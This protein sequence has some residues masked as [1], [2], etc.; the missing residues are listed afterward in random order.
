MDNKKFIFGVIALL[1]LMIGGTYAYYKW[2]STENINVNVKIEGGSVTFN[3]GSNI[4]GVLIP[5]AT[6]EGGIKKI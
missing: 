4:T 2:S 5:T 3:G 6:K 1:L